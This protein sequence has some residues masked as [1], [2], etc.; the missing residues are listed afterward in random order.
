M[1]IPHLHFKS[2]QTV[3]KVYWWICTYRI[4]QSWK[5]VTKVWCTERWW[6]NQF[7]PSSTAL[8]TSL[9]YSALSRYWQ[10]TIQ[11]TVEII[12]RCRCRNVN[13]WLY[14]VVDLI[15]SRFRQLNEILVG[16]V[17]CGV[18]AVFLA[19]LILVDFF[20]NLY[21]STVISFRIQ[22]W[23][24]PWW[25]MRTEKVIDDN[26]N[27]KIGNYEQKIRKWANENL[28]SS[29]SSSKCLSNNKN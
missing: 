14:H 13:R 8:S 18:L 20:D 17:L 2:F 12:N 22:C 6:M 1:Q 4:V 25:E 24:C 15:L 7:A 10:S 9:D 21:V 11:F 19:R 5:S 28:A 26:D 27:N 16:Q 23:C 3:L 29:S